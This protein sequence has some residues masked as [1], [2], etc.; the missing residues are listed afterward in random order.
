MFPP[1]TAKTAARGYGGQHQK[2]RAWWAQQM[3]IGWL[4]GEPIPC[5]RCGHSIQPGQA[6]DLGHDD[7]DRTKYRGPEHRHPT[8]WCKGNRLAGLIKAANN[9]KRKAKAKRVSVTVGS[10]PITVSSRPNT[11]ARW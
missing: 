6:W 10:R 3:Q 9:N 2:L 4:N 1:P 7:H 11:A 5:W 8:P